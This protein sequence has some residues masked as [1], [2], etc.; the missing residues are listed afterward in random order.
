MIA[1]GDDAPGLVSAAAFAW[2][3]FFSV[4]PSHSPHPIDALIFGVKPI[5]LNQH[6]LSLLLLSIY[7]TMKCFPTPSTHLYSPL[8]L[9]SSMGWGNTTLIFMSD[10]MRCC[11]TPLMHLDSPLL[12]L[13]SMGWA[14]TALVFPSAAACVKCV[15]T[16]LTHFHRKSILHLPFGSVNLVPKHDFNHLGLKFH[17]G[18]P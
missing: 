12:L 8:L 7:H 6:L 2:G 4:L 5:Q 14:N 11:P 3:I 18:S 17:R 1:L 9:I 16:P 10:F 13:S 15:P